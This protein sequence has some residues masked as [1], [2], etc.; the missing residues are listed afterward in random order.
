MKVFKI[1]DT[2]EGDFALM[3]DQ[4]ETIRRDP[5]PKRLSDYGFANGADEIR[6]DYD[7]V[8]QYYKERR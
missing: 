5:N 8:A 3:D 7:N 2:S 1:V 4:H 6:H